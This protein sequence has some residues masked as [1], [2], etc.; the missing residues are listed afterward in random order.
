MPAK[1]GRRPREE[2]E[3]NA[4]NGNSDDGESERSPEERA[5]SAAPL[6]QLATRKE[7]EQA[8]ALEAAEQRIAQLT[9]QLAAQTIAAPPS[10]QAKPKAGAKGTGTLPIALRPVNA[11]RLAQVIPRATDRYELRSRVTTLS[12]E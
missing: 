3:D 8:A 9:A 12:R 4:D 10:T 5:P 7:Q 2:E 11:N 6:L 1:E